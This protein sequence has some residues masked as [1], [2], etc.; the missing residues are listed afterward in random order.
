MFTTEHY[1]EIAKVI[2]ERDVEPAN[3]QPSDH[4]FVSGQANMRFQIVQSLLDLFESDNSRFNKN[5]FL[6]ACG[7]NLEDWYSN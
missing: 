3:A 6:R 5:L 2:S 1:K 4:A 7:I